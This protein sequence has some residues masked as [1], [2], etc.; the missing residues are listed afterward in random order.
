MA[1]LKGIGVSFQARDPKDACHPYRPHPSD[2]GLPGQAQRSSLI[3]AT[4]CCGALTIMMLNFGAVPTTTGQM[5][6]GLKRD[7]YAPVD[8]S[9]GEA[10]PCGR[11]VSLGVP[12][13]F[14]WTERSLIQEKLLM[15]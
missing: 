12:S 3:H 2:S 11:G 4:L 8:R 15:I 13:F 1:S 9:E 7:P 6:A 14:K 5:V 10:P